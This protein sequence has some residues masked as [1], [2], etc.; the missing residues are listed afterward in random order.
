L[1]ECP[2]GTKPARQLSNEHELAPAS[3]GNSSGFDGS[4]MSLDQRNGKEKLAG[5]SALQTGWITPP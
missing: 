2:S 3:T 4:Y 5:R 1:I